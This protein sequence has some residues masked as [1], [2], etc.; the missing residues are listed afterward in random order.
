VRSWDLCR[1]HKEALKIASEVA[2]K[3]DWQFV[4]AELAKASSLRQLAS[5]S[6]KDDKELVTK[7]EWERYYINRKMLGKSHPCTLDA[8][9]DCL[10]L[11]SSTQGTARAHAMAQEGLRLSREAFPEGRDTF[12]LVWLFSRSLGL[13][14]EQNPEHGTDQIENQERS[15]RG[16]LASGRYKQANKQYSQLLK[17]VAWKY[18]ENSSKFRCVA[19]CFCTTLEAEGLTEEAN[20]IRAKSHVPRDSD[21]GLVK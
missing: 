13:P 2:A 12:Q 19:D 7:L 9:Y 6:A 1:R 4:E 15:I 16:L 3:H 14:A 11:T 8:L 18:G 5:L 21:R 20:R 10:G 17:E